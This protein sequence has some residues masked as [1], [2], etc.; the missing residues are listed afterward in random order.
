MRE[1][2]GQFEGKIRIAHLSL[3]LCFSPPPS[4]YVCMYVY[5]YIVHTHKHTHK[6]THVSL[7]ITLQVR[8]SPPPHPLSPSLPPSHPSESRGRASRFD[9]SGKCAPAKCAPVWMCVSHTHIHTRYRAIK[10]CILSLQSLMQTAVQLRPR[11]R[12]QSLYPRFLLNSTP[13]T[14]LFSLEDLFSCFLINFSFLL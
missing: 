11:F 2:F 3:C 4:L 14:V 1:K 10:S 7:S 8:L 13:F 5:M 9:D 6:Q 12:T